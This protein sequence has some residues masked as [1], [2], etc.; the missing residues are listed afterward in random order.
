MPLHR[1][2]SAALDLLVRH[3]LE[4]ERSGSAVEAFSQWHQHAHST[5]ART[6]PPPAPAPLPSQVARRYRELIPL[7]QPGPGE[8]FAF[9]VDLDAC[10][11]CKA[12]VTACH[13]LNGLEESESWRSVGLLV[14]RTGTPATARLQHVTTA[15]HHCLEPACLHGCPVLAYEKDPRTGIVRHLDDQCIGC[16]YCLMTCPY[17]VP[18]YSKRLGVVRKCDLCHGRLAEGEAPACAQACPN[19]AIRIGIANTAALR[20]QYPA[21]RR[22]EPNSF[23]PASPAPSLTLPTTRFLSASPDTPALVAADAAHANP[24]LPHLPLVIMLV[25]TQAAAG[26]TLFLPFLDESALPSASATALALLVAG[27]GASVAHLGQPLRAWRIFLGWRRSWLSR[28]ALAL[29]AFATVAMLGVA[30]DQLPASAVTAPARTF[31][32]ALGLG[33]GVVAVATSIMV[34]SVT[35]R[36]EWRLAFTAARF[37]G[38]ALLLGPALLLTL[39]IPLPAAPAFFA[40]LATAGF[41]LGSAAELSERR[42]LR[43]PTTASEHR[44]RLLARGPL[45]GLAQLRFAMSGIGLVLLWITVL[46]TPAGAPHLLSAAAAAALTLGALT[47]RVLFFT[48]SAPERMPGGVPS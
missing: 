31:L 46:A 47:E 41:A 20:Q 32:L 17:E 38:T 24:S 2:Q 7:S 45:Q 39:R 14:S 44:R 35:R 15:C 8:Q 27:L 21:T 12:C 26:I 18:R 16:T 22:D 23:L 40:A 25:L 42:A 11:G 9:E 10:S 4:E 33:L 30:L 48:G 36:P 29:G 5:G 28:E 3:L 13:S 37:A 43:A 19:G 6:A 34:Y 1:D